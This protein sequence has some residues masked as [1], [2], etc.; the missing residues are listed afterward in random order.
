MIK[1]KL[2]QT[3]RLLVLVAVI[4]L[5]ACTILPQ[6]PV[7]QVYL[8]PAQPAAMAGSQ[9]SERSVRIVQPNTS[10]FLNGTRIAVQPQG[11]EIT[12]FSGSRWSDPAPLLLRNRL[13][14]EFRTNG[15]FRSVSSDDDN[16]QAD[17]E[18]GGDLS[19][20][21][22]VY[23]GDRGEVVI[24]FDA[25]LVRTSDRRVMASRSFAVREPIHGTSMDNVVRA[26]GLASD[27]LAAQTLAWARQQAAN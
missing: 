15:H 25:R 12:A 9:A 2:R 5:S 13:I 23:D 24:R 1:L 18:L 10:Q 22:G 21:Q 11:A 7:Q 3:L 26:F 17:L 8:L 16:L 20:F 27:K 6:S 4:P 14:Q 19:S